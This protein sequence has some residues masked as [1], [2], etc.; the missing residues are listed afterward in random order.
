MHGNRR[1]GESGKDQPGEFISKKFG[2]AVRELMSGVF[3]SKDASS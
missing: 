3:G 1:R 2:S